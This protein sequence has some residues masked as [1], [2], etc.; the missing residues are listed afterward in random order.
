[1]ATRKARARSLVARGGTLAAIASLAFAACSDSASHTATAVGSASSE[2]EIDPTSLLPW[3]WGES[4]PAAAAVIVQPDQDTP[5]NALSGNVLVF[6]DR[7]E[8]NTLAT[9]LQALGVA[10]TNVGTLPA[11]LSPYRAIWHVGAFAALSS[12]EQSRLSAFV[13]NGGGLHLTGERPCC[14]AMNAS[15]QS[16]V[17]GLVSGGGIQ[18]GGQGDSNSNTQ[19]F[20]PGAIGG[21]T[22]TPNVLT[23]WNPA[24]SG[25]IAGVAPVNVLVRESAGGR[26]TGAAW[27]CSN[28]VAGRGHLTI[29]MDVNWFTFMSLTERRKI[30]ENVETF[31]QAPCGN[32]PPISR[33]NGPYSGSEGAPVQF[34][35]GGSGDPDGQPLTYLWTFGDGGTSNAP[36]PTHTY[37]DNGTFTVKLQVTDPQGASNETGTTANIVNVPPTVQVGTMAAVPTGSASTGTGQFTDPGADSWT[38]TVDYGDGSGTN[39]LPLSNKSFALSHVYALPG[40]Y[41]VTVT[42]TDDDGGVGAG[43]ATAHITNQPPHASVNGPY[44]NNESVPIGF[45]SAGSGD[46]EG[47]ALT[48]AWTFGDGG[49]STQAD[50]AHAYADNGTYTV[51][52]TVT[53]PSGGTNTATTTAT[54]ANIAPIPTAGPM[55]TVYTG[56]ASTGSGLFKDPGADTWTAIVNYGDGTGTQPLALAGQTFNL[57]HVYADNGTYTVTVTV[58]DDDGG[59]GT[60]TTTATILNRAPVANA[61]PAI[62]AEC[63]GIGVCTSVTLN[64]TGSSDP[65]GHVVSWSWSTPAG[66]L[67]GPTPTSAFPL[68]TSTVT[69]TVTDDDGATATATTTVRV[70]DTTPPVLTFSLSTTTLWSPNHKLVTVASGIRATDVCAGAVAV[71]FTVTS[72]EPINGPGDGNTA[73]DWQVIQ[74]ANGSY[75]LQVRS[76]RAGPLQDRIYTITATTNDGHGNMTT[77]TATVTVPHDQGRGE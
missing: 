36:N 40:D 35:S 4:A 2:E 70:V 31:L 76:E 28:L 25:L 24:A 51:T 55:T 50:P 15:L 49:T 46:P 65:D 34:S 63:N 54:V 59:V 3:N 13:S 26:P 8:R 7:S 69:L 57:S 61:G 74:N 17:N 71:T 75:D 6:G 68:G 19:P 52:L 30:I 45:T 29:L 1:M 48:Y 58:T 10:V 64:G 72:N 56:T 9:D 33:V 43:A 12:S 20:N 14:E 11:D 73:P 42:V 27:S 37:A 5:A 39:P 77:Q 16:L 21:I 23:V 22:V 62:T 44:A 53:D 60:T 47:Q 41:V 66:T 18:V 38:A 32:Q 67:S